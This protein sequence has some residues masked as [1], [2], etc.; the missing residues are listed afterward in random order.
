MS[1]LE[2]LKKRLLSSKNKNNEAYNL[3]AVMEVVGGYSELMNMPLPAVE[4]VVE[5]LKE[6]NKPP[7]KMKN[8]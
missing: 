3:C 5:Y 2:R 6:K 7:K 4:I 1:E 8:K